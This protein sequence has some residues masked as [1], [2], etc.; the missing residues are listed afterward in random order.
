MTTKDIILKYFE[1]LNKK[2]GWDFFLSDD[3]S[4]TSPTQHLHGKA[5]YIQDTKDF[6]YMVTSIEVKDLIIERNKTCAITSYEIRFPSGTVYKDNG[7]AEIFSIKNNK[8]ISLV[9]YFDTASYD[10]FRKQG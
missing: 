5:T 8:I 9:I 3:F 1:S 2:E 6:F 4:F 10:V 7:V